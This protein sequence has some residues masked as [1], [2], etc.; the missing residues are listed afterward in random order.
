MQG[1]RFV[2]ENAA[3]SEPILTPKLD[4]LLWLVSFAIHR[5]THTCVGNIPESIRV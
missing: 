2:A 1:A 5:E 3:L 4:S